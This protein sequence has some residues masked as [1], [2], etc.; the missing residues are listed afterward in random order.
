VL[1]IAINVFLL[2][3]GCF[4]P[5]VAIILM[6]M[7]ILQPVLEAN[8]FDMVWFGVM[9][10]INLEIGLITPPV[11]LNLYILRSV[12]PQVPL[13]TVLSGSMPFV[14]LMLAGMVILAFVPQIALWLPGVL[15]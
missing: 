9:M 11:G 10:T 7:P 14:G 15:R 4:L 1:L 6:T 2:I 5:P 8:N 3:A 12:A 13:R